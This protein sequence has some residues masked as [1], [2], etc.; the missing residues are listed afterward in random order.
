[1]IGDRIT[2]RAALA[3]TALHAAL[4]GVALWHTASDPAMDPPP[5]AEP[6]AVDPPPA[7]G[8]LVLAPEAA[9]A[10]APVVPLPALGS[11]DLPPL[12]LIRPGRTDAAPGATSAPGEGVARALADLPLAA[13]VD[14]ALAQELRGRRAGPAVEGEEELRLDAGNHL[15]FLLKAKYRS[16]WRKRF[17]RDVTASSLIIDVRVDAN[18]VITAA[19]IAAPGTGVDE[20]DRLIERWLVE[21][22]VGLPPIPTDRLAIFQV[23]LR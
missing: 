17:D 10:G 16:T 15:E 7:A 14:D 21:D 1:M 2:T 11:A 13:A 5:P 19:E 3:A 12:P 22:G 6:V 9:D 23:R 20:L 4:V 8:E 18:R